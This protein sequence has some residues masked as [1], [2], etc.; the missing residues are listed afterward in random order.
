MHVA[1]KDTAA[2]D[3]AVNALVDFLGGQTLPVLCNTPI[4]G[5]KGRRVVTRRDL[6][7]L[8]RSA[9]LLVS[10]KG[11]DNA[12]AN[13]FPLLA[14]RSAIAFS[15]DTFVVFAVADTTGRTEAERGFYASVAERN[16][17]IAGSA[18]GRGPSEGRGSNANFMVYVGDNTVL[19]KTIY[20]DKIYLN[21]RDMSLTPSI[22]I[23]GVWEAHVSRLLE[24]VLRPGDCFIDVGANCGYF[25]LLGARLAGPQGLAVAVEPQ[26]PLAAL[27]DRSL[28]VN[29]YKARSLVINAA[30]GDHVETRALQ[31]IGDMTG[32]AFIAPENWRPRSDGEA[33][34]VDVIDFPTLLDRAARV[35]RKP[36]R[37]NVIKI[38]VEGFEYACWTSMRPH[39]AE[40]DAVML[41]MEFSPGRYRSH[42]HDAKAFL[43]EIDGAGFRIDEVQR[44]G[45]LRPTP[46]SEFPRLLGCP[47]FA[48]IA[49]WKGE[50]FGRAG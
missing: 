28:H 50:R 48:D 3:A 14:G 34:S 20:G 7:D 36:V 40:Q 37:P 31:R 29:G 39:I 35:A 23:S 9:F 12:E 44:D 5:L 15:N 43:A 18:A 6:P 49:I 22:M 26:K 33:E 13:V 2:K 46:P 19:T 42:G 25:T 24:R 30:L 47:S 38:D 27:I 41:L 8:A 16:A 45:S 10:H 32:S 1:V 21:S 4:E 17:A 11:R